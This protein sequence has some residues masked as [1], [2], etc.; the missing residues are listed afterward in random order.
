MAGQKLLL[1]LALTLLLGFGSPHSAL[2]KST[3]TTP[4]REALRAATPGA[5][6]KT[7][8]TGIASWFRAKHSMIGAHRTLPLDSKVKVVARNGRSVIVTVKGRGPFVKGRVIDL[9]S[10]AFKK[11]ATL[12]TGVLHVR[13]E[14]VPNAP[15]PSKK[16]STSR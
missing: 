13:L 4:K 7:R 9:S 8:E 5:T 14:L 16:V 10:D 11:L 1:T 6:S 3:Q 2:A 15:K 12:G